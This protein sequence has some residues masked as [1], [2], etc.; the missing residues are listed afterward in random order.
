MVNYPTFFLQLLRKVYFPE[1]SSI[2][3]LLHMIEENWSVSAS[4]KE[5]LKINQGTQPEWRLESRTSCAI[6]FGWDSK[7]NSVR[8]QTP[9]DGNIRISRLHHSP[10]RVSPTDCRRKYVMQLKWKT[11]E[12]WALA[13]K[14]KINLT[15]FHS[16]RVCKKYNE[17][18]KYQ[19]FNMGF[20]CVV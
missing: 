19:Q 7:A 17:A 10:G 9:G 3:N 12:I 4:V 5:N 1:S 6:R 11:I 20:L 14:T 15:H 13:L 8:L 16:F 18:K 2:Q